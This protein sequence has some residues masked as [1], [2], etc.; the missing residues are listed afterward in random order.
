MDSLGNGPA[1]VGAERERPED[2]EVQR[3]LRKFD[4]LVSPQLPL[5]FYRDDSTPPVEAQG[6]RN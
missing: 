4:T 1:V 3:A 6:V 5:S 2:Q